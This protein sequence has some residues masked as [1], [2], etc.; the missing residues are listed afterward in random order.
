[1]PEV[2]TKKKKIRQLEKLEKLQKQWKLA[3]FEV[4]VLIAPKSF[5]LG[6]HMGYQNS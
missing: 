3:K 4:F 5:N 1:M 2:P 6:R